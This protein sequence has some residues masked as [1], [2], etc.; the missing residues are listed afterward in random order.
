MSFGRGFRED[1]VSKAL[2][3]GS[4]MLQDG[5]KAAPFASKTPPGHSKTVLRCL[6]EAFKRLLNVS[7][8]LSGAVLEECSLKIRFLIDVCSEINAF[9]GPK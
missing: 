2:Q 7:K 6:Q 5:S 3:D 1:F 9:T 8:T 4:E